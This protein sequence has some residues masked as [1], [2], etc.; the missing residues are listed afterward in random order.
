MGFYS[1]LK[2]GQDAERLLLEEY[3]FLEYADG[4]TA[5]LQIKGTNI[6]IEKKADSYDMHKYGN[7]IIERY[8]SGTK[9]GGPYSALKNG[10]KYFV[11]TFVQNQ[12]TFVFDTKRLVNR[13]NK[14][15][16]VNKLKMCVKE[17]SSWQTRY[18]KIKISDLQEL[19]LGMETLEKEYTKAVKK[20]KN[21]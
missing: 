4:R 8:G 16:K 3:S 18:Y 9:D 2:F 1:D 10:C 19:D 11:Y 20:G 21:K 13:V 17:N 6:F 12:K 14:L 7:F 5:D 15:I